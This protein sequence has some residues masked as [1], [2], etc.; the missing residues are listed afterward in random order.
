MCCVF[1]LYSFCF[2]HLRP[3]LVQGKAPGGLMGWIDPKRLQIIEKQSSS[4]LGVRAN[5][6]ASLFGFIR[7]ERRLL[8]WTTAFPHFYPIWAE[9]ISL[10][11]KKHSALL[12]ENVRQR[13]QSYFSAILCLKQSLCKSAFREYEVMVIQTLAKSRCIL[14]HVC[15][16]AAC[17]DGYHYLCNRYFLVI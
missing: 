4:P 13:Q 12:L 15:P 7:Q 6:P 10:W 3:M 14:S 5:S 2:Y 17:F 1:F 9:K 11:Q 16:A 8:F